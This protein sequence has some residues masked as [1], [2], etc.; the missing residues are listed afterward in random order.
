MKHEM[1]TLMRLLCCTEKINYRQS[2]GVPGKLTVYPMCILLLTFNHYMKS[3]SF[4]QRILQIMR[5]LPRQDLPRDS[6][7]YQSLIFI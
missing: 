6:P 1:Y 2:P 5:T 3:S 7:D 4:I